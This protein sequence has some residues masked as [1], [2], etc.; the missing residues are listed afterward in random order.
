MYYDCDSLSPAY[1]Q[2]T[3]LH[4]TEEVQHLDPLQEPV[5]GVA[6]RQAQDVKSPVG[7]K[8]KE[9]TPQEGRGYRLRIAV[10]IT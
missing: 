10:A 6:V 2:S 7:L 1:I 9:G 5:Q 8:H 4:S 3:A